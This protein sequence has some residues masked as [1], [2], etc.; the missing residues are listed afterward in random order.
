MNKEQKILKLKS[1]HTSMGGFSRI[2]TDPEIL[3]KCTERDVDMLL[4][5][6]ESAARHAKDVV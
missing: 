3:S 2:I 6:A 1:L 5:I 4:E